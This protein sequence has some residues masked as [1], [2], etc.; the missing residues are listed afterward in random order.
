MPRPTICPYTLVSIPDLSAPSLEHIIPD[1]LGGPNGF[2]VTADQKMNSQLG[3]SV[4]ADLINY[5]ALKFLAM[6]YGVKTRTG[7]VS[8]SLEGTLDL[9]GESIPQAL[10]LSKG[11]LDLRMAKP[12]R[13][14]PITGAVTGVIGWGDEA[15]K[16]LAA[17]TKGLQRKGYSVE[18]GESQSTSGGEVSSRIVHDNFATTR[19][20]AKIAYLSLA[21]T[22]GDDFIIG[23]EGA[24]FRAAYSA[25]DFAMLKLA[26]VTGGPGSASPFMP[27]VPEGHHTVIAIRQSGQYCAVVRLFSSDLLTKT[28][29]VRSDRS[30]DELE[31]SVYTCAPTRGGIHEMSVMDHVISFSKEISSRLG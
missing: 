16:N 17:V 8:L 14:D 20:M 13:T 4:D 18:A 9:D 22:F 27:D 15:G 3:T 26:G 28:F 23:S 21:F 12:V 10:K 30:W 2:S 5:H 29:S 7:E 1:A 31:G 19:G 6:S 25:D 11:Q 24:A